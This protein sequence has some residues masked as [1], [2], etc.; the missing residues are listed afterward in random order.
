MADGVPIREDIEGDEAWQRMTDEPDVRG[1]EAIHNDAPEGWSVFVSVMEFVRSGDPPYE[2]L[3]QAVEHALTSVPGVTRVAREDTEVWWVEG[4]PGGREL[5]QAVA[6]VL[7]DRS[8]SLRGWYNG[9]GG[10]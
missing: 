6:R 3:R 8:D 1:V 4:K 9:L 7:D 10:G 5:V 2:E